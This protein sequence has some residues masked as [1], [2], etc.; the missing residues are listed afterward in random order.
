MKLVEKALEVRILVNVFIKY[1]NN[2]NY[3][4]V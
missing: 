1:T 2:T 3:N 4:F